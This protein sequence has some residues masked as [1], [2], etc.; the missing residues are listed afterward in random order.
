M[1]TS[2]ILKS[3]NVKAGNWR[4]LEKSCYWLFQDLPG[5]RSRS[6][7]CRLCPRSRRCRAVLLQHLAEDLFVGAFDIIAIDEALRSI[8]HFGRNL[9]ANLQE[10]GPFAEQ[11][12]VIAQTLAEVNDLSAVKAKYDL[13]FG[14]LKL[15]IHDKAVAVRRCNQP[16]SY[17]HLTLPTNREV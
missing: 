5:S 10:P 11:L 6:R 14:R 13:I 3:D 8:G 1:A 4:F 12:E 17:T 9:G 16:V 15:A 2:D 7:E